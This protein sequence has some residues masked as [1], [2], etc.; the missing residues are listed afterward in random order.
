[1]KEKLVTRV[2]EQENE[3]THP[4]DQYPID[5]SDAIAVLPALMMDLSFTEAVSR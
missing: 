3:T 4:P 1:M 2:E 5:G